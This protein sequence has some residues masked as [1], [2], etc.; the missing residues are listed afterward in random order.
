MFHQS[1]KLLYLY[2]GSIQFFCAGIDSFSVNCVLLDRLM[3]VL[4]LPN[5][6]GK[7]DSNII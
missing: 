7:I 4:N 5:Y 2:F 6:F 1:I 3:C